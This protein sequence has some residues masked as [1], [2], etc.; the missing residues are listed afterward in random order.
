[1]S[2]THVLYRFFS[3]TGQLLYV[4]IT[5][6]PP[7]RFKNHRDS[8]DWWGEVSGITVENYTSR[9]ELAQAERR[10]IQVEHPMYNIVHT[11]GTKPRPVP[12]PEPEVDEPVD[13]PPEVTELFAP[14]PPVDYSSLLGRSM[15]D[16]EVAYEKRLAEEYR[17]KMQARKDCSFC[18]PAGYRNGYLCDHIDHASQPSK[19]AQAQWRVK[20]ERLRAVRDGA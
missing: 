2:D 3:A 14:A 18:D 5:M 4:G 10:A 13:V 17:A 7:Q 19:Y 6:N 9:D 16:W 12:E 15:P 8:K 1:M 11:K 20:K